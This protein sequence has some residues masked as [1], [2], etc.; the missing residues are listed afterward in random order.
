MSGSTGPGEPAS[1]EPPVAGT[2]WF[3]KPTPNPFTGTTSV[4]YQV[5]ESGTQVGFAV[6]DLVGREVRRLQDAFQSSGP[7]TLSWDGRGEAGARVRPGM[8][9]IRGS[10]GERPL[11]W[12]VVL[13]Q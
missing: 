3:S 4:S 10:I 12:R 11:A 5:P 2:A 8:Y 6:Y 13:V 9:F 7:H 1:S